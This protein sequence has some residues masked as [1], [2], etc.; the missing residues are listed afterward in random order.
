MGFK[1]SANIHIFY[2]FQIKKCKKSNLMSAKF[3]LQEPKNKL[4]VAPRKERLPIYTSCEFLYLI[5]Q[6]QVLQLRGL[7]LQ[8]LLLLQLWEPLL[9]ELP[10]RVQRLSLSVNGVWS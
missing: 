6:P 2:Y 9:R 5:T 3:E 1:L 7:L 8:E 4:R 10:L